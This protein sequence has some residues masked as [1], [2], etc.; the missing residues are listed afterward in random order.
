MNGKQ[1]RIFAAIMVT[2]LLVGGGVAIAY[3]VADRRKGQERTS[4]RDAAQAAP[5]APAAAAPAAPA[6]APAAA[7]GGAS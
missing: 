2:A 3:T 5:A 1:A 7:A 4:T 6:A